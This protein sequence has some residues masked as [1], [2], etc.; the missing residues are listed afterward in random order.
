MKRA[1][2]KR[3]S[4]VIY[5]ALVAVSLLFLGLE[6]LTHF[7]FLLHVAAIPL[8]VLLAVF[9]IERLLERQESGRRR[10]LLMYIKSTM[11]RSEMRSL[12]IANFAALKS[13]R[14]SLESIGTADAEEL[15]RMRREAEAVAYGPPRAMEAVVMEYVKA[16]G[17]WLAFMNR[18]LEFNF[19]DVFENMISILHFI[20]DIVAFKERNPRKLFVEEARSRPELLRKTHKVLGDGIRAFLDYAL[21]LKEK[22][23]VVFEELMSDYRRSVRRRKR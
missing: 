22:Q 11:F 7:E 2:K 23:P 19:D 14:I 18:A 3:N 20:S 8:E 9:I 12:F 21:E 1:V 13:P 16:R 17:V 15:R 4:P 5:I 10:R 6:L